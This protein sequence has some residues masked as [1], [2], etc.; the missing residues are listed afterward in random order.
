MS[1]SELETG[2]R[3]VRIV[4]DKRAVMLETKAVALDVTPTEAGRLIRELGQGYIAAISILRDIRND[5]VGV[6]HCRTCD[7]I[8][9]ALGGLPHDD[10]ERLL[11]DLE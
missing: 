1:V 10:I 7:Q 5:L 9:T 11:R 8:A 2:A 4:M 6:Q 3:A